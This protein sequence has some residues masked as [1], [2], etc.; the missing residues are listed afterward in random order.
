L[1]SRITVAVLPFRNLSGN[2]ADAYI[3]LG[4]PEMVLEELSTLGNISVIARDSS[5]K[6]KADS[7]S[8]QDIGLQLGANYLIDGSVQR[9][10]DTLRVSA[11]LIDA[12]AG[13]QIWAE[14]F[15]RDIDDIFAIQDQIATRV[16]E[17]IGARVAKPDSLSVYPRPTSNIDAYLAYLRGRVLLGRWTV[18]DADAAARAF[19]SAISL[20]PD[21]A[22]AYASLYDARMM[23]E[24]RRSG[25]ATASQAQSG[26]ADGGRALGVVR[27]RNRSLID[28][29]LA[30]N[31]TSGTAYFARAIWADDVS[32]TRER[33]F[34]RGLELDPSNGRGLTAFAEFLDRSGRD[35]E[36]VGMLE[37]AIAIDPLSPRAYFWQ[38][39]RK[40]PVGPAALEAD[41]LK[42]LEIDPDYVPALQRY[43]KYRWIFHGEQTEA[44]QLIERALA[45]D[46]TNPWLIHCDCHVSRS[47]RHRYRDRTAKWRR[48]T[49]GDRA[50]SHNAVRG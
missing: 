18:V 7:R 16:A 23:A 27:A 14:R 6:A 35:D 13:T 46:P 15:D 33:D 2:D 32:G 17:A 30:L 10:G 5:F 48:A 28:T 34:R 36:A 45:L 8:V 37:R 21:F 9:A 4:M 22:A 19:E 12:Q 26:N 11:Q 49:R 43:A 44:I 42:V 38:A 39:M 47:G 40:L 24:D 1:R 31:P 50:T 20:D 3:A 29:A 41:I 25:G